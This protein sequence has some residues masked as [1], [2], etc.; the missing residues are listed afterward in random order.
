MNSRPSIVKLLFRW[1]LAI[2]FIAAGMNHFR[3]PELYESMIPPSFPRPDL[4]NWIS[5]AAEI[6]G[7]VGICVTRFRKMAAWGLIALLV[8]VFPANIYLAING[9]PGVDI[10]RWVLWAR[11]PLQG[12]FIWWV[13]VT[14]LP[15]FRGAPSVL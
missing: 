1:L 14:C 10:A 6:A 3:S 7:G 11:L 15:K 9:W 8:A 12:V 13:Y 5:G 4:L 2:F